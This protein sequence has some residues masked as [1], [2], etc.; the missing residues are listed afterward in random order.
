M[1]NQNGN[2]FEDDAKLKDQRYQ[3]LLHNFIEASGSIALIKTLTEIPHITGDSAEEKAYGLIIGKDQDVNVRVLAVQKISKVIGS[4]PAMITECLDILRDEQEPSDLRH[5]VLNVLEALEFWSQTFKSMRPQYFEALYELLGS[6][7]KSLVEDAT[8]ILAIHKDLE[9]QNRLLVGLQTNTEPLVSA[10]KAIQLLSYDIHFN[11]HSTVR[12]IL[13]NPDTPDDV[14]VQAVHAL[15]TDMGSKEVISSILED[16]RQSQ[17]V[18]LASVAALQSAYPSEFIALGKPVV[19]DDSDD[20]EVRAASLNA[21]MFIRDSE[22]V[23]N[24]SDFVEKVNK[25]STPRAMGSLNKRTTDMF[26]EKANKFL[27][28][29]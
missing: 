9:V 24:D 4:N 7:V 16:K 23:F 13:L 22:Q 12:D 17:N 20:Q 3:K 15:T 18:R 25:I 10:A 27:D 2:Q 11:F 14:R 26:L 29:K 21:L 6:P 8:G 1:E 5:E 28:K 19:L